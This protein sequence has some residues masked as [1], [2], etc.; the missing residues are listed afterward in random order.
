VNTTHFAQGLTALAERPLPSSVRAESVR[1]ILNVVGTTI[2]AI[3]AEPVD[4]I[5][6]L[7]RDS[8][9]STGSVTLPGRPERRDPV[10]AALAIGTAAHFD[11][12]DDTHLATVV[13]PAAA[14][15]AAAY[16]CVSRA[17]VTGEAFV[18]AVALGIEAQLRVALAM[19]PWHYD[20]GW[21]ITGTVGAIGA[22]VTVGR[23]LGLNAVE[24][25]HA[26]AIASSLSVG[27]REGFGTMVKPL[28]P[29]KAGSNGLLAAFLARRGF[30]GSPTALEGSRGFFAV[31]SDQVDLSHLTDRFGERWE[32]LNNTYKPY[33]CGI[34]THP[35]IEAAEELSAQVGTQE[36]TAVRLYGHSLVSE[37]TG[38]RDPKTGLA[39][40]F[41]T[42]HGVAAGLL[43]GKVG[44]DQYDDERVV[45]PDLV[46]LRAKCELI[47][48]ATI[49]RDAAFLQV[50][51]NDG[52][53]LEHRVV[54]A[55]GSLG[56]PLTEDELD[57]KVRG[58]IM[59][60][61]PRTAATIIRAVRDLPTA[62]SC[63]DLIAT[64]TEE[65]K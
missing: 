47:T 62:A 17:D 28:H 37:L 22:A 56:R 45:Q 23:L 65:N 13:H 34:V 15:F 10:N 42:V 8:E 43:D 35:G 31:L 44:L 49:D 5:V 6:G 63:Q 1:S 60:N 26:I 46:T 51:L 18:D 30:T 50:D 52:T 64:L 11:D 53:T 58:L 38:N 41:S 55:R 39:A 54:H 36:I 21:H 9:S 59:R 29:G 3:R 14:V 25:G 61:A 2:G 19:T 7:D 57:D 48:D 20:A 33:P 27:H 4:I 40:R 32:I 16:P 12:F 24:L